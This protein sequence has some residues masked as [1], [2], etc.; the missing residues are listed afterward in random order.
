MTKKTL[1]ITIIGAGSTYTPELINGFLERVSTLPSAD[2]LPTVWED[3][4]A[5]HREYLPQFLSC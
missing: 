4:L 5:T 1:K 3:L 2:Q